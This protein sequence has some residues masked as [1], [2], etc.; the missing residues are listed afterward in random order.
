[1]NSSKHLKLPQILRYAKLTSFKAVTDATYNDIQDSNGNLLQSDTAKASALNE[2]FSSVFINED[3]TNLLSFS[4][5]R[6][7]PTLSDVDTSPTVVF[8]KLNSQ[9]Q[10]AKSAGPD[11]WP[12]AALKETATEICIPLSIIFSK[13]LQSGHLAT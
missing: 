2:Y 10:C 3:C 7:V 13:S 9:L 1:M 8:T 6:T 4:I 5:G 11:G 12:P